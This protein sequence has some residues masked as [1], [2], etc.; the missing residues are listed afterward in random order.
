V[1]RLRVLEGVEEATDEDP[2][3]RCRDD[4]TPDGLSERVAGSRL[5]PTKSGVRSQ[6]RGPLLGEHVGS[7]RLD[8]EGR[9]GSSSRRS[10]LVGWRGLNPFGASSRSSRRAPYGAAQDGALAARQRIPS[11]RMSVSE[12]S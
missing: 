1:V 8:L 7:R 2:D 3:Q 11:C 6:S 10:A 9:R 5:Q 12:A 4:P